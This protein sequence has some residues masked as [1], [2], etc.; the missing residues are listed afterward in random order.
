MNK[1]Y[2]TV[3][4]H[5]Q[6]PFRVVSMQWFAAFLCV[7]CVPILPALGEDSA[8]LEWPRLFESG[9]D[10]VIVHQPQLDAWHDRALLKG[11]AAITV[12]LSGDAQE[13]YGVIHLQ[14]ATEVDKGTR[15]VLLNGIEISEITFP[16]LDG[17]L[18]VK[19]RKA[20]RSAL[21]EGKQLELSLDRII[22]G[23]EQTEQRTSAVNV[24]F[25]PPPIFYSEEP[26][27]LVIF[28][29]EPQ[30]EMVDDV[31]GLMF[32]VNTNWDLLMD[33]ASSRYYLLNADH[34]LVTEDVVKGPWRNTKKLPKSFDKL[35]KNDDWKVVRAAVPGRAVV[36][37]PKP[38]VS[39]KP[40][41]MIVTEGKPSFSP[42]SGTRLMYVSNTDSDVFLH[43][44]SG[45]YYFLSSGR[46]FRSGSLDG[47]WEAASTDLPAEFTSIPGNHPKSHVLSSVPGTSEAEAA[48]LLASVPQK[49]TVNRKDL[50]TTVVYE[51][52]PQFVVI[53]GTSSPLYYAINSPNDVFKVNSRYYTVINGVWFEAGT[54]KG[55]WIV[56]DAVPSV[57]YSIPATHP[58]HNVTYVRIYDS[59]PNTVVVGY[60]SGYSGSYVAATG[61]LMFGLGYLIADSH[62]DHWHHYPHFHHYH[63]HSHYFGYGSGARYDYYRGGYFHAARYYGPHGGAAGR[64]GYNPATGR[65]Y[66]G[67]IAKG[68]YGSVFAREAFNPYTGRYAARATA[69]TPYESWG[70]SVVARGDDWARAGHRSRLGKT[71]GGIETSRGGKAVGG[72]NRRTD[73]GAVVGK[74]RYGDV[75]VGR[76]GNVYRRDDSGWQARDNRSWRDVDSSRGLQERADGRSLPDQKVTS[77]SQ[78]KADRSASV[79]GRAN[80][81]SRIEG[82]GAI[83]RRQQSGSL[84][85]TRTQT[86]D[87]EFQRRQRG[88]DRAARFQQRSGGGRT[89]RR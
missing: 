85:G 67:G 26:A 12:E 77:L 44:K 84:R 6:P 50:K 62:H 23:L 3:R 48:V 61:V 58:K 16:N 47:P 81:R 37:P 21:P 29:G 25:D 49:A 65:Y 56:C 22:A 80:A 1:R 60:T 82:N 69:R 7:L 87:R 19:S 42:V 53:E 43:A 33:V 4:P 20:V 59:T 39:L 10:K 18:A 36:N 14:S 76:D 45:E 30:F 15:T 55:P 70:R 66:R 63:Y 75:Y 83:G 71:V 35:P 57:I 41:E 9:K 86:L 73:Q 74:N 5:A 17:D 72:Y 28:M 11:R 68:P 79:N 31:P 54:T 2:E 13:Y 52:D 51:G 32:A 8:A 38:F 46:W 27:F 24:S 34:W 78:G 88:N 64:A 40:A 89:R